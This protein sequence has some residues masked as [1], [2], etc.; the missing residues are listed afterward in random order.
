MLLPIPTSQ[1][2]DNFSKLGKNICIVGDKRITIAYASHQLSAYTT[3]IT[4]KCFK[5]PQ[6]LSFLE[7]MLK[8]HTTIGSTTEVYHHKGENIGTVMKTGDAIFAPHGVTTQRAQLQF[9]NV[10]CIDPSA[11]ELEGVE[12]RGWDKLR[13][14]L[15]LFM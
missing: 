2:I 11:D 4:S 5:W 1:L 7:S 10:I 9:S 6:L 15:L 13:K 3:S 12:L 14:A 8:K